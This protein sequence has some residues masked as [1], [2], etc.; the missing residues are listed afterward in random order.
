MFK[1]IDKHYASNKYICTYSK[2][3]ITKSVNKLNVDCL[4]INQ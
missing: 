1:A 2:G 3:V 4:D